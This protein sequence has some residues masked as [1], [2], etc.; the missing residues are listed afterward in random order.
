MQVEVEQTPLVD[1][2]TREKSKSESAREEQVTKAGVREEV[3]FQIMAEDKEQGALKKLRA[4]NK[5][6]KHIVK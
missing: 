6:R 4:L 3:A 2:D 5:R 1:I